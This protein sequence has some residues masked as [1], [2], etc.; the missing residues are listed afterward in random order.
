MILRN[1]RDGIIRKLSVVFV[2]DAVIGT[3]MMSVT[4]SSRAEARTSSSGSVVCA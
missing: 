3:C 4:D 2:T 1:D